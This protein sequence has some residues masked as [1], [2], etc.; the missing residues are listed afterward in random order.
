[1]TAAFIHLPRFVV[2]TTHR[3]YTENPYLI[4]KDILGILRRQT[5]FYIEK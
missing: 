2:V 1:M 5:G 3:K 4:L